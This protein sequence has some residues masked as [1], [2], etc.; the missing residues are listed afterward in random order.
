MKKTYANPEIAVIK[1]AS[2]TKILAGSGEVPMGSGN[3][4]EWGARSC[5][6][7]EDWDDWEDED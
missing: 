6:V 5:E 3:A 2:K 1:I 7:D 4:S